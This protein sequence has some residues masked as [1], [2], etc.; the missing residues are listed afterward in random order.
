MGTPGAENSEEGLAEACEVTT[1]KTKGPARFHTGVG[2]GGGLVARC[3]L[4]LPTPRTVAHQPPPSM[5]FPRRRCWQGLHFLHQGVSSNK[6]WL[7]VDGCL[8]GL[9]QAR[10][11]SLLT[12][13]LRRG[14]RCDS[15]GV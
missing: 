6:Q 11:T 1:V 15:T 7:T 5:R 13:L 3:C 12:S 10:E 9:V 2:G 8:L 14:R 4:T